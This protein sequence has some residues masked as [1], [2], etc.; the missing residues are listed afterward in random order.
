MKK[1][2][3]NLIVL[4]SLL[5]SVGCV[6]DGKEIQAEEEPFSAN[7]ALIFDSSKI[8]SEQMFEKEKNVIKD[9]AEIFSKDKYNVRI[10]VIQY[11]MKSDHQYLPANVIYNLDHIK[12]I[13]NF[14]NQI[15]NIQQ[16][17]W[18]V[19]I[20]DA[21]RLCENNVFKSEINGDKPIRKNFV[22]LFTYGTTFVEDDLPHY[23]AKRIRNAGHHIF[24]VSTRTYNRATYKKS[25]RQHY[26]LQKN[27]ASDP[28]LFFILDEFAK[29]KTFVNLLLMKMFSIGSNRM[30][31]ISTTTPTTTTTNDASKVLSLDED[32]STAIT[33]EYLNNISAVTQQFIETDVTSHAYETTS[34]TEQSWNSTVL[35]LDFNETIT[36]VSEI[37]N[38]TIFTNEYSTNE[39]DLHQLNET[40][41]ALRPYGN[42]SNTE[43]TS[44]TT[45]E[46]DL[47]KNSDDIDKSEE[48]YDQIVTD[49]YSNDK[50]DFHPFDEATLNESDLTLQPDESDSYEESDMDENLNNWHQKQSTF[51]NTKLTDT[52]VEDHTSTRR[53][54]NLI[55]E[56]IKNSSIKFKNGTEDIFTGIITNNSSD[57][58]NLTIIYGEPKDEVESFWIF[59]FILAPVGVAF[60]LVMTIH[61]I[62]KRH[63]RNKMEKAEQPVEEDDTQQT[64]ESASFTISLSDTETTDEMEEM[65]S[66][67]LPE[68][69]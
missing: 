23:W 18:L 17:N 32:N 3:K 51:S 27:V 7:V 35:E 64:N 69:F 4:L 12:D 36:D 67:H 50:T 43:P 34:N 29:M 52:T 25:T 45:V 41:L 31:A 30:I 42:I 68:L 58:M 49:G 59:I 63:K 61:A 13:K 55:D 46:L 8:I 22:I 11:S 9:L 26:F 66:C 47:S 15:D 37:E 28:K 39:T 33:D 60:L 38:S 56:K 21:L 5:Y 6:Y 44:E 40:D 53:N 10:A 65:Q 20:S 62:R 16:S 19:N 54:P 57:A 2:Q 14:S 24:V 48:D 1:L